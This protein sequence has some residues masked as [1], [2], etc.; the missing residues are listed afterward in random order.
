MNYEST[1]TISS[2][3]LPGVRFTIR[4]MSFG[5][6]LEFSHRVRELAGRY[7]FTGAGTDSIDKLETAA[8]QREIDKL[9]F[10]WGLT[11]IEGLQIDG[12]PATVE[13][14]LDNGP[15]RFCCEIIDAVKR[16][17]GLSDEERKN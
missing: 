11:R 9:Y 2:E 4:R 12:A 1:I 14:L 15:E 7:E 5:R 17:C 3:T 13:S 8:L 6:R 16:E 10:S